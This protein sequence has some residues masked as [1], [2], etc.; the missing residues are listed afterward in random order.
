MQK[1][2]LKMNAIKSILILLVLIQL[3]FYWNTYVTIKNILLF[4]SDNVFY[5]MFI[6]EYESFT[7]EHLL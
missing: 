7:S 4:K 1:H 3:S 5:M 2:I 6:Y